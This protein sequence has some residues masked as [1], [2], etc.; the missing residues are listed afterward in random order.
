MV[1]VILAVVVFGALFIMI[2][3]PKAAKGYNVD[4]CP[5][6]LAELKIQIADQEKQIEEASL[7]IKEA[8]GKN[9]FFS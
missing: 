5:T 1:W 2:L 8:M 9:N 3:V 7:K 6:E 4:C